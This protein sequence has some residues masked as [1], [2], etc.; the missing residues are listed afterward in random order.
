MLSFAILIVGLWGLGGFGLLLHRISLRFGL[1]PLFGYVAAV[2]V[3]SSVADWL[4]L[5]VELTPGVIFR[6]SGQVFVPL[7]L[8]IFLI[9]YIAAGTRLAQ[10]MFLELAGVSAVIAFF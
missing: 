6:I 4:A 2:I 7:L 9:V 8:V 3:L 10:A 5:P 1:A